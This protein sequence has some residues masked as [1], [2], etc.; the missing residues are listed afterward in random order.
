MASVLVI[1]R[2]ERVY[3]PSL[4][5]NPDSFANLPAIR[6]ILGK[7]NKNI[8]TLFG[9]V[10]LYLLKMETAKIVIVRKKRFG[11][12]RLVFQNEVAV[13]SERFT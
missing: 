5:E 4:P 13:I 6:G 12:K 2:G 3:Y 8:F 9:N 1:D 11:Q 10:Y 7:V